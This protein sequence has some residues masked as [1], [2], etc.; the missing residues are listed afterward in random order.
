MSN[1]EITGKVVIVGE[2]QVFASGFNKRELVLRTEEKYPQEVPIEFVKNKA[3]ELKSHNL[4]QGDTVTVSF[5]VRGREHNGRWYA[6]LNGWKVKRHGAAKQEQPPEDP[7][8]GSFE[9][10]DTLDEDVPF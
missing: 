9:P 8:Q 5:D 4:C 3:D 1:N 10:D 2:E 7:N 6:S